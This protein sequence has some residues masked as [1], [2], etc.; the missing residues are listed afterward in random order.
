MKKGF[1]LVEMLVVIGIIVVLAGAAIG[2]F[3]GATKRAQVARGRE[4]VSNVATALSTIYQQ[5]GR[6]PKALVDANGAD[7]NRL[8]KEAGAVLA[9]K[10][11]LSLSYEKNDSGHYTLVGVD[12]FGVV[13][14]WAM[15][16]L[17]NTDGASL[18]TKVPSGGTVADH[19]V[20]F[21]ID[22]E[23]AG[24]VRATVCGKSI[25]VRAQ[26]IAWSCGP[27]G[28]FDSLDNMGRSD[29]IFSFREGQIVKFK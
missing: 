3:S 26:A 5:D 6:W 9:R 20:R 27:D 15:Q 12:R 24:L 2:A 1:T 7:E 28:K 22:T 19:I 13:D 11:V 21:A 18:G 25:T 17:R 4:L 16:K 23:G 29:D 10:G 8:G 14:P